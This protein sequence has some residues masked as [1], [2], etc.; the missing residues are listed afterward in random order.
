MIARLPPRQTRC[1][2]GVLIAAW[3]AAC[4]SGPATP[5]APRALITPVAAAAL[6]VMRAQLDAVRNAAPGAAVQSDSQGVADYLLGLNRQQIRES[7]GEPRVCTAADAREVDHRGV[8]LSSCEA[9]GDW[10][11]SFYHL[12]EGAS[13]GGPELLLHF[14]ERGRCVRAGWRVTR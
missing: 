13:G 4:S 6:Q 7:L 8:P 11:F 9:E 5:S 12:P 1:G 3:V 14:D 10:H 2:P